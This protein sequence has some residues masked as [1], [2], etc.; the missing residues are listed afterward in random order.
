MDG[1]AVAGKGLDTGAARHAVVLTGGEPA[2]PALARLLPVGAYVIAAD[3]G[4]DQAAILGLDVDLAVGD[5]DSLA[6]A[7]LEAAMAAGC[8][9]ERHPAAKDH[10]DLELGLRAALEHGCRRVV[11]VGGHGGRLDHLLANALVLAGAT[12]AGMEVEALMGPG[13]LRVIRAGGPHSLHGRAGQLVTLLALGGAAL[14]VR[15]TGLR[16][17]LADEDLQPGSTRGVS[18]EMLA[19]D[20]SVRVRH[21][22]LLV[23]R[24]G[25]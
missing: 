15:T 9:V 5:F 24:P 21:G 11:V 18:N 20:A 4:L 12:T 8:R 19:T 1:E 3:S 16:Y 10:T 14:G 13:R 22:T 23:V 2:D 17:P 25:P 6:P 7:A